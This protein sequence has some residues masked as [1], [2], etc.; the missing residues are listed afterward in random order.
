MEKQEISDFNTVSIPDNVIYDDNILKKKSFD[1]LFKDNIVSYKKNLNKRISYLKNNIDISIKNY[2]SQPKP[3]YRLIIHI[4]EYKEKLN[5][6]NTD[7]IKDIKKIELE[8][9]NINNKIINL[10]LI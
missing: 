4:K 10:I 3:N 7:T 9:E 6:I 5:I 2:L 8:L 1:P